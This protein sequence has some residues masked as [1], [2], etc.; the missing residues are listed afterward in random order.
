[1]KGL[2][3]MRA[4][5]FIA[6][7][8]IAIAVF[9]INILGSNYI[10]AFDSVPDEKKVYLTFDDGPIPI[11][12]E[13]ILDI[14]KEQNIKA[15]F[16]V[17]GKEIPE[18]EHILKRI[19]TE[20]HAIGL[21]TYNHKFRKIY[22][23]DDAFVDEMLKAREIVSQAINISP[24]A[25]RFPGGSSGRMTQELLDKLHSNDMKV[26]D[27]NLD[28]HDGDRGDIN[29]SQI[30]RNGENFNPKYGRLIILA[31]CNSNNKNTIKALPEIIRYYKDLGYEFEPIKDDTPDYYYRLRTK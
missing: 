27:W 16:F 4:A 2:I 22:R 23:S 28:L 18:R 9:F 11:V 31:H 20:G 29:V 8:T 19:Y 15:T 14:L 17:V 21:H 7:A 13:K 25:I 12:T 10:Y 1:M 5:R 26:F 30:I 24:K 6:I 3:V